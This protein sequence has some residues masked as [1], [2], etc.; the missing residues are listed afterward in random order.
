MT[1]NLSHGKQGNMCKILH[2]LCKQIHKYDDLL[3]NSLVSL[4]QIVIPDLTRN[5]EPY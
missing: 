1:E 5:P 3:I 2:I 4:T